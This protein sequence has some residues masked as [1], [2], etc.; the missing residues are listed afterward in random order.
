M[1]SLIASLPAV[2]EL[3]GPY[4]PLQILERQGPAGLGRCGKLQSWASG[5]SQAGAEALCVRAFTGTSGI[6]GLG[7][8]FP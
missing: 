2:A 8:D 3:Q 6:V 5:R 1:N 7:P 4:G